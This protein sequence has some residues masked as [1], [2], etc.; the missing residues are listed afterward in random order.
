MKGRAYSGQEIVTHKNCTTEVVLGGSTGNFYS[1]LLSIHFA[2]KT[3]S[4]HLQK[5]D[6]DDDQESTAGIYCFL[7]TV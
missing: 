6:C 4:M 1:M 7:L 2:I 5:F 3:V